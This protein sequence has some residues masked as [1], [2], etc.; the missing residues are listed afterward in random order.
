MKNSIFVGQ[1]NETIHGLKFLLN[2]RTQWF[3]YIEELTKITNVNTNINSEYLYSLN[4][5]SF[6]Y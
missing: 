1:N 5:S 3:D 2:Q 6:P 4:R